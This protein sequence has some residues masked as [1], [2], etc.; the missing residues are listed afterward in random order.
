M[1]SSFAWLDFS[2]R[3][4]RQAMDVIDLFRNEDTRDELGLGVIRDAFADRLFPGT[5]TIQT[6]VRYFLFIP[7]MFRTLKPRDAGA[8]RFPQWARQQQN[9]LREALLAGGETQGVIGFRAGK[10]VQRLPSSVY[11]SGLRKWGILRSAGSEGSY[12]REL[13][14]QGRGVD[15]L[16]NDDGEPVDPAVGSLWDPELPEPPEDWLSETTF[17]LTREEARYLEDRLNIVARNSLLTHL[18]NQRK[19]PGITEFAWEHLRP[20]QRPTALGEELVHAQNF[21]ESMHGASLLYNLMLAEEKQ[22]EGLVN[23]HET[24]LA[25]WWQNRQAR[26]AELAAW[27]RP[28]F[29]SLLAGWQAR[30]PPACRR[31]V[32][33][34]IT[35][36]G[37]ASRLEDLTALSFRNL[38]RDR[39]R[40]LKGPRARLGNPAALQ[41]WQ[42]AS[43]IAILDYRWKSP[44]RGMLADLVQ[45]LEAGD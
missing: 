45:G 23:I 32:E 8:D 9:K 28:R 31:L 35:A 40:A 38:I 33:A 27:D 4:R 34:W 18:I 24:A 11:W 41:Y 25:G 20:D 6:R 13:L 42:G 21:S 17:A 15:T 7:W 36:A 44:V 16:R 43:G 26:A 39:E 2:D 19:A 22:N 10:E 5:S 29:W 37:R 14:L 12:G 1:T 3:D 30:V